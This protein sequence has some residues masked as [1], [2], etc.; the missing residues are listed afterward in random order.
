MHTHTGSHDVY[1]SDSNGLCRAKRPVRCSSN[2]AEERSSPEYLTFSPYAGNACILRQDPRGSCRLGVLRSTAQAAQTAA[3]A[4]DTKV[5]PSNVVLD[6]LISVFAAKTP[7]EWRKL[8]AH[9]KQWPDLAGGVL[10]RYNELLTTTRNAPKY[11]L[12]KDGRLRICSQQ[13][14]VPAGCK[15]SV[16]Q[17]VM[18]ENEWSSRSYSGGL[19]L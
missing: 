8:I 18:M 14:H 12:H 16:M 1:R 5:P 3:P 17:S 2:V 7:K 6:K 11:M 19:S 9:S 4:S 10:Q 13:Q 15:I